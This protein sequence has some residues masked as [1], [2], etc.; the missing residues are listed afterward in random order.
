MT[1]EMSKEKRRAHFA[2]REIASAGEALTRLLH[3]RGSEQSDLMGIDVRISTEPEKPGVVYCIFTIESRT[4]A[5]AEDHAAALEAEGCTC[6]SSG[7]TSV[8]CDCTDTE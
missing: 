1:V 3:P 5:A 7:P 2:A 4:Q 6:T 8:E